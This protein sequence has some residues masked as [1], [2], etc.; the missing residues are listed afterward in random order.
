[1]TVTHHV[2]LKQY[3]RTCLDML[4]TSLSL[5]KIHNS[6]NTARFDLCSPAIAK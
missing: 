6:Q 4:L 2:V 3:D 5:E 1:M